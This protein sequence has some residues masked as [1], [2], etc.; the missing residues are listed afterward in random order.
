MALLWFH[1]EQTMS[2]HEIIEQRVH[3][4]ECRKFEEGTAF[5]KLPHKGN[6]AV[7]IKNLSMT[8]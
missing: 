1:D 4:F 3:F 7:S 2:Q 8:L 6:Q 5:P